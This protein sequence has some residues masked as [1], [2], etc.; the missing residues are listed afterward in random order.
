MATIN[1][2]TFTATI[3]KPVAADQTDLSTQ[4]IMYK[5]GKQLI[6]VSGIPSTGQ[7]SVT[8][9]N[10][11]NCT[12]RLEDDHKTIT[13]LSATSNNGQINISINVENLQTYDKVIKVANIVSTDVIQT[14][15]SQAQ[16]LSNK[17]TWVVKSGTSAS[18][19]ELTDE[20]Y[21]LISKKITLTA[22]RINLNGYVS[23]DDCNWSITTDGNIEAK[24]LSVEDELSTDVLNVNTISNPRYPQT[25][26]GSIDIPVNY[27]SGSDDYTL[28][29]VLAS[30]DEA[31]ETGSIDIIK[32]FRTVKG[33]L[34]QLPK[35]LNGMTVRIHMETDTIENTTLAYFGMGRIFIYLG[36]YTFNGYIKGFG[37]NAPIYI[38]G[39]TVDNPTRTGYIHPHTALS[40]NSKN[41]S[42]GFDTCQYLGLYNLQ[43][44][45]AD[46]K[47]NS[48]VTC[49]VM[50]QG[51]GTVY[52]S[53]VGI[54]SCDIGFR[55]NNT[56]Q[57]HMSSSSGIANSYGFQAHTGGKISFANNSQAGGATASTNKDSGGQIWT[58]SATFA[59]GSATTGDKNAATP[60]TSD[61]LTCKSTSGDTYRSTVYNNWKK[62]GTC[63]QGDWGYG[64]STGVWFFGT[65]F[66]ELKGKTITKVT[67]TISRQSSANGNNSAVEHKIWMHNHST[68]PS[69]APTLNK[70][71]STTFTLTRGETKT[72]TITN[73]TVLNAIKNGTCKGF[74]IRHN[75]DNSHYSV[76]SGSATV[77]IT[78][79]E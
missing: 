10:T 49:C 78:Y 56:A 67:I 16:Q 45:G 27:N 59:T 47:A 37:N 76:C 75:Y 66:A 14:A 13:L 8:I 39:G 46:Y 21:N 30:I 53:N 38:Y 5:G 41:A 35:F 36:G 7:Y 6:A 11:V 9:T 2:N 4:V 73:S 69:G 29:E 32:K 68:R 50:A 34:A 40:F 72:I 65:Q 52:C 44:Y 54:N 24:N 42:I 17:F 55:A 64:D 20:A 23:N 18:N 19:M 31:N 79:Q 51:G 62:D 15:Y 33:A 58:T 12:A 43:I 3:N 22:D 77:K 48:G 71:W 60:S 26:D 28:N 61:T 63:R 74:A 1:S 25:L 70:S 57:I